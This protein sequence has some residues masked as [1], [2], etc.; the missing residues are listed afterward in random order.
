[1]ICNKAI[2][3]MK[4][5]D[6]NVIAG[7]SDKYFSLEAKVKVGETA[8]KGKDIFYKLKFMDSYQFLSAPLSRLAESLD[9]FQYVTTLKQDFPLLSDETLHKKGM[10]P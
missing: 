6:F 2:G 10:F 7:T 5:W 3:K 9:E 8:Q 4:D 1:M